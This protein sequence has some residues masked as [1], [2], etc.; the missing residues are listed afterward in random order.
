MKV[1]LWLGFLMAILM[2]CSQFDASIDPSSKNKIFFS[3]GF[4]KIKFERVKEFKIETDASWLFWGNKKSSI[5]DVGMLINGKI[6]ELG[7]NGVVGLKIQTE[8][9]FGQGVLGIITL[10]IY[11]ARSVSISGTV[12]KFN[13]TSLNYIPNLNTLMVASA[14]FN[15]SYFKQL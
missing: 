2:G 8:Q 9:S 1:L 13:A 14:Q 3:D 5:P 6:T 10:G 15:N 4:D 7:G 12:V 11:Q